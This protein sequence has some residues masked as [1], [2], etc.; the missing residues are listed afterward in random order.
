MIYDVSVFFYSTQVY[1]ISRCHRQK[2]SSNSDHCS[3]KMRKYMTCKW[4]L[5][6]LIRRTFSHK[7]GIYTY[8]SGESGDV[9]WVN[10]HLLKDGDGFFSRRLLLLLDFARFLQAAIDREGYSRYIQ[11]GKQKRDD[12]FAFVMLTLQDLLNIRLSPV[13]THTYV[14][15]HTGTQ[16][17][18][19]GA[20]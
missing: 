3:Q 10:N 5:H 16:G 13:H 7:A 12:A 8:L 1:C 19:D 11:T 6:C 18:G 9:F 4:L 14:H 2:S 20:M 15:T 17:L